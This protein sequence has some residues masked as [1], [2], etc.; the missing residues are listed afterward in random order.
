[1]DDCLDL[2][3]KSRNIK[4]KSNLTRLLLKKYVKG[5]KG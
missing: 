1:M 3:V 5:Y 2:N 4:R